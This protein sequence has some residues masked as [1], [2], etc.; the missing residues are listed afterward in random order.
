M[1]S[2]DAVASIGRRRQR[3]TLRRLMG[4]V[5]VSAL[6]FAALPMLPAIPMAVAVGGVIVAAGMGLPIV[7]EWGGAWRWLPWVIWS[8]VLV[9]C[10][11]ATIVVGEMYPRARTSPMPSPLPWAT[12]VVEGLYYADLG[13]SAAASVAVVVMAR[14]RLRWLAWAIV[15]VI[16]VVGMF[17]SLVSWMATSGAWF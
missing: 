16:A 4:A 13:A 17:F 7:T 3:L 9:A 5:A 14:G 2:D 12:R 10:P 11:I 6:S 1:S 15:V 8:A